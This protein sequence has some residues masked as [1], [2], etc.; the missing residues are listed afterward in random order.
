MGVVSRHSA[1]VQD[2]SA[3]QSELASVPPK[4][5]SDKYADKFLRSAQPSPP[6]AW[7]NWYRQVRWFNLSVIVITPL[8]ALYGAATTHLDP[9]TFSF[10]VLYYVFNMIGGS[11]LVC[12]GIIIFLN[13]VGDPKESLL[14]CRLTPCPHHLYLIMTCHYQVTT[15]YGLT[16]HIMLLDHLSIFSP[17]LAEAPFKARSGGG[18]EAIGLTTGKHSN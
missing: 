5:D 7:S 18:L 13:F 16:G 4:S 8:V 11:F 12:S 1:V 10:C 6:I 17:S 14:V 3:L 15:A 9:R 2:G